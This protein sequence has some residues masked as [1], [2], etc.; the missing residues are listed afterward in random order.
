LHGGQAIASPEPAKFSLLFTFPSCCLTNLYEIAFKF[1]QGTSND[2]MNQNQKTMSYCWR[3]TDT[4]LQGR[5]I[6]HAPSLFRRDGKDEKVLKLHEVVEN[7]AIEKLIKCLL[8]TGH[9]NFI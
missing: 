4:K 6:S 3:K 1:S 8:N 9:Q 2:I 7:P 5:S